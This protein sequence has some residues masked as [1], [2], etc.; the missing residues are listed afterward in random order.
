MRKVM[1]IVGAGPGRGRTLATAAAREG[2]NSALVARSLPR[3]E[4]TATLVEAEGGAALA[5]S[6]EATNI[7]E[8]ANA[9]A[10]IIDRWGR[11]DSL[12]HILPPPHRFHS[13]RNARRFS[14]YHRR[15][16]MPALM[17]SPRA[18]RACLSVSI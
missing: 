12:V 11:I 7:D 2:W 10:A 5:L 14:Q 1:L 3:I 6:A 17:K 9:V 15:F 16:E 18:A 13:P 4:E 8:M